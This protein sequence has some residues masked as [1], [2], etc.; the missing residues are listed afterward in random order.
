M[1][2]GCLVKE[3]QSGHVIFGKG[4][5]V[6]VKTDR[7]I[8]EIEASVLAHLASIAP[9]YDFNASDLHVSPTD[10]ER[11]CMLRID[12]TRYCVKRFDFFAMGFVL[13]YEDRRAERVNSAIKRAIEEAVYCAEIA[14]GFPVTDPKEDAPRP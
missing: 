12:Y 6:Y 4:P 10:A 9:Q 8:E 14:D 5:H 3:A 13:D 1:R 7:S 11:G 2:H